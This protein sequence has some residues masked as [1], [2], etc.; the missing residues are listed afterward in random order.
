MNASDSHVL[1]TE[2]VL[3]RLGVSEHGLSRAEAAARLARFGP[4]TLPHDEPPGVFR[5]FTR[6]FLSP[7]IYILLLAAV[8]SMILREW[9]DAGFIFGVLLINAIIGTLQEY[10]AQRTA[11]ALQNLVSTRAEVLREGDAREMLGAYRKAREAHMR[12]AS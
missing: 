2:E 11:V 4:N 5:I 12:E 3:R 10:S 6:Q 9:S 8:V 1:T 7:L